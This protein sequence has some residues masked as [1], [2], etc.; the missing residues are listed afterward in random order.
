MNVTDE[1]Y[2]RVYAVYQL[3]TPKP[4]VWRNL[5]DFDPIFFFNK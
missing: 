3:L 1:D 4:H 5:N 2:R